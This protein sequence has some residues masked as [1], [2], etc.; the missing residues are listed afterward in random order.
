M[1]GCQGYSEKE[2]IPYCH[3]SNYIERRQVDDGARLV[4]LIGTQ[5]PVRRENNFEKRSTSLNQ[6]IIK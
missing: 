5:F 6:R 1:G 2:R 3:P 4:T